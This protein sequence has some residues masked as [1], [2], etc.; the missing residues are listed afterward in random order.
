MEIFKFSH[1]EGYEI[2]AANNAKEAIMY[3][4]TNHMDDI[5]T[6]DLVATGGIK[7]RKLDDEEATELRKIYDDDRKDV[8]WQSYKE[9]AEKNFNGQPIVVAYRIDV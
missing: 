4:F 8:K 1:S 7:I 3:Y 5:Y 6:D 9:L 2:I